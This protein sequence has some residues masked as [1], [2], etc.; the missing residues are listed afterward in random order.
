MNRKV[1]VLF[2]G[3]KGTENPLLYFSAKGYADNGY[4]KIFL[5]A[6]IHFIIIVKIKNSRRFAR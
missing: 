2:P 6:K 3:G 1:V 4:E 5:F